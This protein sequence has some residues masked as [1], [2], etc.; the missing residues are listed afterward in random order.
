MT[1]TDTTRLEGIPRRSERIN[2]P[3]H[4]RNK[5]LDTTQILNH[6]VTPSVAGSEPNKSASGSSQHWDL[7]LHPAHAKRLRQSSVGLEIAETRGYSSLGVNEKARRWLREHRF[8]SST[9]PLPA[10]VIPVWSLEGV[11]VYH[12]LRPDVPALDRDDRPIKYPVPRGQ[13]FR[14]DVHP[15]VLSL[16]MDRSIP[17]TVTEGIL[18][19]DALV[20]RGEPALGLFG[21]WGWMQDDRPLDDWRSLPLAAREVSVIFDSDVCTNQNVRMAAVRLCQLLE[22][23]SAH[24]RIIAIP[25]AA[26]S[27]KVGIDDFL[28][29]GGELSELE[30]LLPP[31]PTALQTAKEVVRR[32]FTGATL[33]VALAIL[34]EA[35]TQLSFAPVVTNA[36]LA[37]ASNRSE[38]AVKS[39]KARL[40]DHGLFDVYVKR[41]AGEWLSTYGFNTSFLVRQEHQKENP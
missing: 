41:I 20:S 23:L 29:A 3:G 4:T 18:K 1:P 24:P 27:P 8:K 38:A 25:Q 14:I 16:V 13:R 32:D 37:R 9:A 22:D 15:E 12:Q 17:L 40:K 6:S 10:M 36:R 35:E 21:C 28:F 11:V 19:A 30:T 5:V 39:A 34:R 26:G 33:D 7:L 31:D 2:D